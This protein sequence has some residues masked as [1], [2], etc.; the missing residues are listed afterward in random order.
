MA[1]TYTERQIEKWIKVFILRQEVLAEDE[2]EENSDSE[3]RAQSPLGRKISHDRMSGGGT[4]RKM[5]AIESMLPSRKTSASSSNCPSRKWS[6]HS[7]P[8]RGEVLRMDD[9]MHT[10]NRG[11]VEMTIPL[12]ITHHIPPRLIGHLDEEGILLCDKMLSD[13]YTVAEIIE[14]F[15]T[16]VPVKERIARKFKQFTELTEKLKNGDVTNSE[17]MRML[18]DIMEGQNL[19][20]KDFLD[21]MGTQFGDKT[22]AEMEEML[23]KG[24]SMSEVLEHF[25]RQAEKEELKEKLQALLDDQNASTEEVF[26]ALKNQLGAEDQAKI[27]E[28]LAAG[29]TMEQIINHFM[30]GGMDEGSEVPS[31]DQIK[32]KLK[33]DLKQKISNLMNDPNA[34]TEQ[35][36]KAMMKNL[37]KEEQ[38]KVEEMLKL[39]MTMDDIIKHFVAGGMDDDKQA[40]EAK[41]R[42]KDEL[43]GKLK[44]MLNDPNASTED[45]FNTMRAQLSD[46]DQAKVDEMLKKGMSMND[47]IN[48]FMK[49]GMDEVQEDNEFTRKMK[50]LIGGKDLNDEELLELMKSQLGDGSKAEL[51]AMLAEGYSLQEVM[52]HFMKH[53]KT[54]EE[55]KEELKSKL[56]SMLSDPSASSKDVFDA[57]MGK[58]SQEEQRKID[59]LLRSGLTMD[60]IVKRFVEGGMEGV[61]QMSGELGSES[62]L[63]KQLRELAGGKNLS[64]EEMLELMKSKLG[65]GSRAE[66]ENMLAAGYTMEEAMKFMMKHGKTEEEE[67]KILADK[68][69]AAMDG[70]NLTEEEKMKFLKDNLS[71]EAK[72]TMDELLAQGYTKDEIIE[73]FKKHGNNLDA[74]DKELSNPSIIFDDEPPDAHL[75]ANRDVFTVI[76]KET[77]K[78]EVPYMSPCIKNMTFKQFLDCVQRLVKGKGLTHREVLDIM[79][80]RMGGT[81]LQELRELRANGASLAD[82][83]QYLLTKDA[84]MRKYTRRK[85]RL[86]AQAKVTECLLMSF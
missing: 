1:L 65:E 37:N 70:Q 2:L 76:S 13:G 72:R 84:E 11:G 41:Q 24:M 17:K 42:A 23:K 62:E 25:Q 7:S 30:N 31:V 69:R 80:F 74:I 28:M 12:N 32:K 51:E 35:V 22:K 14:Y 54:Q 58:L 21:L 77:V 46:S 36:F 66:L 83:V 78:T 4:S 33:D 9:E 75:Y 71:D 68:I 8:T 10:V 6:R 82:V 47:I 43:K 49:G 85:A 59:E 19:S 29:M 18:K 38:K 60:E 3:E 61:D 16:Y 53:G 55:E 40:R 48:H 67:Q 5:S 50:E 34:S 56:E 63:A 79:E 64:Q 39:G 52:D 81:F 15:K 27:Q 86:E 73:L 57:M 20:E 45:V 26:N 44:K